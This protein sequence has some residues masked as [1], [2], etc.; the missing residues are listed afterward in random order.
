MIET[1]QRAPDVSLPGMGPDADAIEA[2]RLSLSFY[3]FDFHPG[4]TRQVCSLRD[5]AWFDLRP[6]TTVFGIST[7]RAFSHRA[8]ADRYDLDFTPLSDSDGP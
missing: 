5:L 3:L 4:C 2:Y 7:D 6:D 8:F 1:G